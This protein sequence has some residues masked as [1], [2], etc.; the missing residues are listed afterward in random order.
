MGAA[1]VAQCQRKGHA[2]GRQWQ[3]QQERYA[4]TRSQGPAEQRHQHRPQPKRID[5]GDES[6]SMLEQMTHCFCPTPHI[7]SD[8]S[9]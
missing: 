4:H 2:H 5:D 6:Q 8:W 9:D 7:T 3:H 1:E